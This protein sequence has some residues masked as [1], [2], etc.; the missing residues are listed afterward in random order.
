MAVLLAMFASMMVYIYMYVYIEGVL[1]LAKT[2]FW[3]KS[4]ANR[5]P[6]GR[7]KLSENKEK[8]AQHFLCLKGMVRNGTEWVRN[9]TDSYGK[10]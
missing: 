3:D 4:V 6:A 2:P 10:S 8:N 7:P 1:M 9:G 5:R